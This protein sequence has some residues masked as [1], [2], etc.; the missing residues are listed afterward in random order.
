M[1][2]VVIFMGIFTGA[3]TA[4]EAAVMACIY[5]FIVELFIHKSLKWQ[6]EKRVTVGS[7]VT[8]ATL[9][10]IVAGA[11]CFGRYLTL[12]NIPNKITEAV[13]PAFILPWSSFWRS[14]WCFWW[15]AC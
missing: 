8:S 5:A 13:M 14:I 12:E 15:S 11:T 4:N 9:L 3:F 2:P 1:L 7:A 10:I 6:D